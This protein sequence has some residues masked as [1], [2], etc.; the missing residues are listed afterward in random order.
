MANSQLLRGVPAIVEGGVGDVWSRSGKN[1]AS[2]QYA[3]RVDWNSAKELMGLTKDVATIVLPLLGVLVGA[4][5]AGR[6]A[7]KNWLRQERL[8]MYADLISKLETMNSIFSGKLHTARFTGSPV[9]LGTPGY[10]KYK[11]VLDQ[12]YAA[13]PLV[14]EAAMNLRILSP[15]FESGLNDEL[16][17]H[18]IRMIALAT[19]ANKTVTS[20]EWDRCSSASAEIVLRLVKE[21]RKELAIPG[22]MSRPR[23]RRLKVS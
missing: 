18:W 20:Q 2:L 22:Q 23:R 14:T 3:P 16:S 6:T 9:Q 5:L 15:K 11:T 19:H 21:S 7:E 12:F 4:R 10:D 8:K 13:V 17:D 1:L